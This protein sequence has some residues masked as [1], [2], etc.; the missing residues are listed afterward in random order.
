MKETLEQMM[1][2]VKD[3]IP[4]PAWIQTSVGLINTRNH[5]AMLKAKAR[6][7]KLKEAQK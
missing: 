2:R 3:G 1:N 4:G 5:I 6:L 7:K